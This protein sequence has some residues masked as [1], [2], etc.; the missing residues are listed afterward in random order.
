MSID[1]ATL[2]PEMVRRGLMSPKIAMPA[3][4]SYTS[5]L[6]KG[7][8]GGRPRLTPEGTRKTQLRNRK[9]A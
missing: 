1:L 3:P 6:C 8:R 5:Q 4:K 2:Y 7:C 9:V